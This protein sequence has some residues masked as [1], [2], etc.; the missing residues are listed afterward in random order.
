MIKGTVSTVDLSNILHVSTRTVNRDKR[1]ITQYLT[2]QFHMLAAESPAIHQQML[3]GHYDVLQQAWMII[4]KNPDPNVKIQ[5]LYLAM[6][7]MNKI[8]ELSG[9][10]NKL[11]ESFMKAYRFK[12]DVD[13]EAMQRGISGR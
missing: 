3:Y 11:V 2:N 5:A 10:S 9:S 4:S 7:A 6:S 13:R 12:R 1:F 8:I